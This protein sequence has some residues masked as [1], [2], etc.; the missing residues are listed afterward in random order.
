MKRLKNA[1]AP[2]ETKSDTVIFFKYLSVLE[3]YCNCLCEPHLH[4]NLSCVSN[5]QTAKLLKIYSYRQ[6]SIA[7][8]GEKTLNYERLE[9]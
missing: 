2:R 8:L 5:T 1:L 7:F 4:L 3:G 9:I 6:N